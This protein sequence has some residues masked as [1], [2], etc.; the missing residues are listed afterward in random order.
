MHL[1]GPVC[2]AFVA[3]SCYRFGES[4]GTREYRSKLVLHL[5]MRWV[6]IGFI[7]PDAVQVGAD[8]LTSLA[9]FQKVFMLENSQFSCGSRPRDHRQKVVA[10]LCTK[11]P[12]DSRRWHSEPNAIGDPEPDLFSGLN[13][14]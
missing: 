13:E 3:H 2:G 1:R 5:T 8:L 4:D 12:H 14:N 7:Q 11:E 6:R 10:R 9:W